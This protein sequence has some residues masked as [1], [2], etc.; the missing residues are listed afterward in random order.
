MI[1]FVV[2]WWDISIN[3]LNLRVSE[4]WFDLRFAEVESEFWGQGILSFLFS[5]L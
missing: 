1:K 3:K 5:F 4:L 2:S